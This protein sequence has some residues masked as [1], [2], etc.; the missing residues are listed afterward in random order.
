MEIEVLA[1]HDPVSQGPFGA[2]CSSEITSAPGMAAVANAIA[3]AT[4]ARV[5]DLP[6]TPRRVL[7]AMARVRA[8]DGAENG[9]ENASGAL[10]AS[11]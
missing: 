5:F 4:G 7:E 8:G 2:K 10:R 11:A 1:V 3:H 9:A 6:A